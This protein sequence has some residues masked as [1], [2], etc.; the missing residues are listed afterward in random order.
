MGINGTVLE[1]GYSSVT[2]PPVAKHW[3]KHAKHCPQPVASL[4]LLPDFRV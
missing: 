1:A 4:D 2:Q 3:R